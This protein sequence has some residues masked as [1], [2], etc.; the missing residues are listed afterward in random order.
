MR[1]H[2]L[3]ITALAVAFVVTSGQAQA[4]EP[5]PAIAPAAPV[6]LT[7]DARAYSAGSFDGYKP[8]SLAEVDRD[9]RV[10]RSPRFQGHTPGWVMTFMGVSGVAVGATF[11]GL[12]ADGS[13]GAKTMVESDRRIGYGGVIGGVAMLG[14]GVVTLVVT[15]TDV[16]TALVQTLAHLPSGKPALKLAF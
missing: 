16:R 15:G 6:T 12:S 1:F 5:S 4:L 10:S 13:A 11:L 2:L 14:I 8:F 3:L 7:L 9:L